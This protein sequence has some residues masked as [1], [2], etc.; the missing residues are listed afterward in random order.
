MHDFRRTVKTNMTNAGEQPVEGISESLVSHLRHV[1][2]VHGFQGQLVFGFLLAEHLEQF[3]PL[4][5]ISPV[6]KF[7]V[8]L[9]RLF[10]PL[11]GEHENFVVPHTGRVFE[12][13]NIIT[14]FDVR[15][16]F[17]FITLHGRGK[18]LGFKVLN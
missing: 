12:F 8:Q 1:V 10:F 9:E 18:P 16:P 2:I 3:F 13:Y 11:H 6:H 4:V 14:A 15:N 5:G 17:E 7:V